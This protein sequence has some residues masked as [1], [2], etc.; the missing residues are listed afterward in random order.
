M[1]FEGEPEESDISETKDPLIVDG[2]KSDKFLNTKMK[3]FILDS[4]RFD[5]DPLKKVK[6]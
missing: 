5:P 2:K 4:A 6:K 1:L 3:Q